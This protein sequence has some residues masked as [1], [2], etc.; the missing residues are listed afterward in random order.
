MNG[1]KK[2]GGVARKSRE[3]AKVKREEW[4]RSLLTWIF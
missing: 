2:V 4:S 3:A 1:R